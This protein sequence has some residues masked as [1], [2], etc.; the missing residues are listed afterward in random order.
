VETE[1]QLEILRSEG[2]TQVQGYLFSEPR[3]VAEIPAMI[4][5]LRPRARAA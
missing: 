1:E 4:K 5:K 2:C 3:P